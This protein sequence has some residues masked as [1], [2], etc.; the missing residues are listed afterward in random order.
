MALLTSNLLAAC[1]RL[2]ATWLEPELVLKAIERF[3]RSGAERAAVEENW[4]K[5]RMERSHKRLWDHVTRGRW[6]GYIRVMHAA[7]AAAA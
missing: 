2:T 7:C 1:C 4:V 5:S 6:G 3:N